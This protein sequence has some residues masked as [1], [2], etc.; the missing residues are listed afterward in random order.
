M[1]LLVALPLFALLV[2]DAPSGTELRYG[3]KKG[4]AIPVSHELTITLKISGSEQLV[5][6]VR[7][8]MA[9]LSFEKIRMRGDG[10]RHVE[11]SKK[12]KTGVRLDVDAARVDGVYDDEPYEFDF[13]KSAPPENL[14]DDK[15]KE[16]LWMLS[17]GGRKYTVGARGE[18]KSSDINQDAWGEAND[19]V[20]LALVRLPEKAVEAGGTWEQ[21]WTGERKQ[22]D[23]G[24]VW[25]YTQKAKL[26][27]IEERAG[28]KVARISFELAGAM[29][30]PEGKRDPNMKTGGTTLEASGWLE[31]DVTTGLPL[32]SESNGKVRAHATFVNADGGA[33]H[34]LE[35][36]NTI[37]GKISLK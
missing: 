16:T 33:D 28:R 19:I 23:N 5:T 24:A 14:K 6:M 7:S 36:L 9:F 11:S 30:V 27:K 3:G 29:I 35:I 4:D 10:T 20:S 12:D 15:L 32:A 13:D 21:K 37:E 17:M 34:E 1:K 22:K 18:Y 31:M 8:S 2:Q 25:D 26:E